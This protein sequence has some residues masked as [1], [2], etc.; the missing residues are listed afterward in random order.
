[1]YNLNGTY[2]SQERHRSQTCAGAVVNRQVKAESLVVNSVGH[3][4]TNRNV[5]SSLAL[6]GR[7]PDVALSG[8]RFC[9]FC[10]D[11]ALPY[12]IDNKAFSLI[13]TGMGGPTLVPIC[14]RYHAGRLIGTN[15]KLTYK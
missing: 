2:K 5:P 1:M 4:P 13:L 10:Q 8:L 15:N 9:G 7:N 14:N 11:R 12:P 3:R 6:K